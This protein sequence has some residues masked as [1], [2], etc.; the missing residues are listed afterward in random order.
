MFH[1]YRIAFA[2]VAGFL[3]SA[4]TA[5]DLP[6]DVLVK[7]GKVTVTRADYD[8]EIA[9]V[10]P[11]LRAEFVASSDRLAKLLNAM[12]EAKTLAA[13]ARAIGLDK[14]PQVQARIA[15]QVEKVLAVA[16]SEQI[17]REAGAA[18]D[19]RRDEFMVRVREMYLLNKE[20]FMLPEQIRAAHILIRTEK[21][22]KDEALK[23]AQEIRARAVAEGADFTALARQ[24]SEDATAKTNGGNLGW[25]EA[26]QM[27]RGFS[28]G[29]FALKKSGEISEPVLS[30]FG[31]HIIRLDE[32]K[33]AQ[34]QSYDSVKD[35]I[36]AEVRR[37]YIA[38][39]RAAAREGIS[40]DSTLQVNQPA[41]DAL[42]VRIDPESVRN[43]GAANPK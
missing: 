33:P 14:D 4:S 35:V 40:R 38:Q 16:R 10:R 42:V 41:I 34:L 26:K 36:L 1:P 7:S 37:D 6:S 24:Y 3:A 21:R 20:R 32:R 29:A 15:M 5:A 31:Y 12:L 25:F 22:D 28:A 43:A 39:V 18:F 2:C 30:S 11:D 27:D 13:E 9:A 17:E 19:L 8:L 23:L